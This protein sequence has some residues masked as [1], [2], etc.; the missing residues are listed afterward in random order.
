MYARQ[1]LRAVD[2]APASGGTWLHNCMTAF[3]ATTLHWTHEMRFW[4]AM[5]DVG[6]A[7]QVAL[8]SGRTWPQPGI[9]ASHAAV[10]S[11]N[12]GL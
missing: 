7:V 6:K 9:T 11:R 4:N 3:H 2:V 8:T 5:D 10:D 12:E 1:A